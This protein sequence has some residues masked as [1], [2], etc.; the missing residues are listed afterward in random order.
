M[1]GII[2]VYKPKGITSFD[3]V[4]FL[5]RTLKEKR[6]GHTGTLDPI[7]EGVLVICVGKATSMV[8]DIEAESKVYE[9]VMETGYSTDTYDS[10]GKIVKESEKKEIDEIELEN[11]FKE[12]IGEQ[13][14]IPPMYSA[15]KI[16]GKRLYE[17][18][19]KN[20][21]VERKARKVLIEY[22]NFLGKENKIIRF[23]TKV[24]KG[25]Y[26]RSLIN[27]IGEKAGTFATMTGLI[28]K[29]VGE[30]SSEESY[31]LEKIKE[32]SEKN[33]FSFLKSIEELF[34]YEKI[35][36]KK[37]KERKWYI[38]GNVFEKEENSDGKYRVYFDEKF[39]GLAEINEGKI[40][41][42]KYFMTE[43]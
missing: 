12:F 1:D 16:D 33:D 40:K 9:A 39:M 10:E 18:A 5:K 2:N 35:Q 36:I 24:S 8:S 21:E 7:A 4:R 19:R 23:E 29:K 42:Y 32:L 13:Q 11:I 6:I 41:P 43:N 17:L 34:P 28:R 22:I 30:Y 27:D 37:E 20:I 3:V 25:T 26:I 31:T 15:L 14:Q 38:N